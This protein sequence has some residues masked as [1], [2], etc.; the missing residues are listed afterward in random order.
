VFAACGV[1]AVSQPDAPR[2]VIERRDQ[3]TT[4][5]WDGRVLVTGGRGRDG[6]PLASAEVYDPAAGEWS[7]TGEMGT[8]RYGH[9]ASVLIDGRVL[10]TGGSGCRRNCTEAD[11]YATAEI[12]DPVSE[13]WSQ[14]TNMAASRQGHAAAVLADGRVLVAGGRGIDGGSADPPA[15]FPPSLR[16]SELYDPRTGHWSPLPPMHRGRAG[17]HS[18]ALWDGRVVMAGGYE[19]TVVQYDDEL[20]EGSVAQYGLTPETVEV[21]DP[22]TGAWTL[23]PR[24]TITNIEWVGAQSD[25]TLL[26]AG[27]LY[28]DRVQLY[29]PDRQRWSAPV[30]RDPMAP[31]RS[32]LVLL[33]DTRLLAT[34][35]LSDEEDADVAAAGTTALLHIDTESWKAV[36]EMTTPRVRHAAVRLSNGSVLV[37]GGYQIRDGRFRHG[38]AP[39]LTS[40]V[41]DPATDRWSARGPAADRSADRGQ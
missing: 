19:G 16:S 24:A 10:V 2:V 17:Q 37:Y 4:L 33:D 38:H 25:G 9:T 29:D 36:A 6:A 5:L 32:T 26:V 35:G 21:F 15:R 28:Q 20:S 23:S 31:D 12:Y 40:E 8:P 3:T 1:G 14:T 13:T 39:V 34:G 22:V 7:A 30:D 18:L 11:A 41:Y 27:G